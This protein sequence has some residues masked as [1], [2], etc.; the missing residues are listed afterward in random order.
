MLSQENLTGDTMLAWRG[1]FA[2]LKNT[3]PVKKLRIRI[4]KMLSGELSAGRVVGGDVFLQSRKLD[5][6][7]KKKIFIM[8]EKL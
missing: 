4:R 2:R 6:G 7:M 1:Y 3:D 8:G 5:W